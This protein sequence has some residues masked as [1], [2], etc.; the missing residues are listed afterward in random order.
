[1]GDGGRA[2]YIL[3]SVHLRYIT[4]NF[5]LAGNTLRLDRT[6]DQSARCLSKQ[7]LMLESHEG[8]IH[9]VRAECS[10]GRWHTAVTVTLAAAG[11]GLPSRSSRFIP[12]KRSRES[13]C[14]ADWVDPT[15]AI[16]GVRV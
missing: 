10:Y 11:E 1:M 6:V 7:S 2:P 13:H 8:H 4:P 5:Y 16:E 9:T 14:T 15:A 3:L 12:G